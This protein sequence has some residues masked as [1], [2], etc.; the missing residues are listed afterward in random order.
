MPDPIDKFVGNAI[1]QLRISKDLSLSAVAKEVGVSFQ[2]MQKYES[3]SNRISA[4][5]LAK[6]SRALGVPIA[7]FFPPEYGGQSYNRQEELLLTKFRSS[8]DN[9]RQ[10]LTKL[11]DG[12]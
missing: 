4:S 5:R 7:D 11:I 2:Q 8:G 10:F 9:E 3:A 6:I 12:L 1:R